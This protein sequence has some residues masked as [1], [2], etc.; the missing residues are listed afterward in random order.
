MRSAPISDR[1]RPE[2][3]VHGLF[4][5]FGF[6]VA[7][8]FPFLAVYLDGRGLSASQIGLVLAAMAFA[9]IVAN[10]V[11]GH[12]A[13]T[14][15]GRLVALQLGTIGAAA[16]ALAM[17]AVDGVVPIAAAASVLAACM[18][19]TGPN[20]DSIALVHLGKE[21][22]ADYGRIRAWESLSYAAGCLVIGAILEVAGLRWAM[23]VY[24]LAC[25]AVLAWT[26]TFERDRPERGQVHGRLGAVG[27]VFR[28]A[29][30]FWGFLAATLLV[31]TGFNAA[32]NFISLK[33]VGEGGGPFLIGLGTAL[34]GLVEVP[35]MRVSS[36]LHARWGLRR[37]YA[38]GCLI[39]AAGFLAWGLIESPTI[40]SLLTV[41]EGAAFALLFTTGVVVI[42]RLVPSTLYS[43]ANAVAAMVG[44]GIGPIL[45]AGIGGIV[46]DH[47][48]SVVLYTSAS[49]LAAG[50]AAIAWV[51]LHTPAL[52]EPGAAD[53]VGLSGEP[54]AAPGEVAP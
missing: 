46:F 15:I 22:M 31:W 6:V 19:A 18:V 42:G 25:L 32:W 24:A 2:T 21:R 40:V 11:W 10:P 9:R 5:V 39:Y 38:L 4:V 43:S 37:V 1:V 44:F 47:A 3:A 8:F 41:F 28:A 36:R 48:G 20:I 23:P 50:G 33:I 16:G 12:Q 49:I 26:V 30:R 53:E 54:P 17:N 51:A 29:P 13:D 45:G 52:D 14:R 27:A 34:G 7:A 35:V